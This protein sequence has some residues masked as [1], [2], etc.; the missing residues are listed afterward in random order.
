MGN[1]WLAVALS[2][3]IALNLAVVGFYMYERVAVSRRHFPPPLPG[4]GPEMREHVRRMRTELE[5]R[6][7]SLRE[8]LAAT[9]TGLMDLVREPGADGRKADS[10]LGE[11]G[12]IEQQMNRLAF[13][14]A[15]RLMDSLPPEARQRLLERLE[16]RGGPGDRHWPRQRDHGP[17]PHG[18]GPNG[19]G[20]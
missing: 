18:H 15:R 10:L 11:I 9:R 3:S 13:E 17:G 20:M 8:Q 16:E 14:H 6:L 7:D 19:P 12:R 2:A 4:M 1:R 5:P